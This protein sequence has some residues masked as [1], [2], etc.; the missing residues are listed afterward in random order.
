MQNRSNNL[1]NMCKGYTD[2][3][4]YGGYPVMFVQVI[5]FGVKTDI[6]QN[7]HDLHVIAL[8]QTKSSLQW[9]SGGDGFG[10]FM[11]ERQQH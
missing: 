5:Y 7:N 9:G 6:A 11:E 8:S 2:W 4:G 3:W 10:F 1:T